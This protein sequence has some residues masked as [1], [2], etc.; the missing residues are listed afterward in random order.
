MHR[1]GMLCLPR[2]VAAV[3]V[4]GGISLTARA[5]LFAAVHHPRGAPLASFIGRLVALCLH[6]AASAAWPRGELV[7]SATRS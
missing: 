7:A 4:Y 1:Q 3:T 6:K 2:S 5:H